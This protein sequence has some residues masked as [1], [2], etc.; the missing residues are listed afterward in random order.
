V[1]VSSDEDGE[2][3]RHPEQEREQMGAG[4][5]QSERYRQGVNARKEL[6]DFPLGQADAIVRA[7][8]QAGLNRS[9]RCD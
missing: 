9:A 4:D 5:R 6:P 2:S 8:V 7:A 3:K 1:C